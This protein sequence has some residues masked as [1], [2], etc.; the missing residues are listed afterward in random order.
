MKIQLQEHTKHADINSLH[1]DMYKTNAGT[2]QQQNPITVGPY[3][4]VNHNI[5][6]LY[7]W[8]LFDS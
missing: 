5:T 1:K 7:I 6:T 8:L 2:L 4:H 3:P